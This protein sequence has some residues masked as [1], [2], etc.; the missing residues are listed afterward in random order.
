MLANF[1][2]TRQ[3]SD[4]FN[5]SFQFTTHLP[6]YLEPNEFLLAQCCEIGHNI[7][8]VMKLGQMITHLK[9]IYCTCHTVKKFKENKKRRNTVKMTNEN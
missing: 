3:M 5:A 8:L 6:I 9:L 4:K 7:V 2:T 1:V